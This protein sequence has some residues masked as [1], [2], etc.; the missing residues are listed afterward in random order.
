M[1]PPLPPPL[2]PPPAQFCFVLKMRGSYFRGT[3]S[4][5]WNIFIFTFFYSH[6]K[7][8]S[9]IRTV[10]FYLDHQSPPIRQERGLIVPYPV[11]FLLSC[12][13][14]AIL[15]HLPPC[16]EFLL[17][18]QLEAEPLSCP[19]S[20]LPWDAPSW[21]SMCPPV[22]FAHILTVLLQSKV[23]GPWPFPSS[24]EER[25]EHGFNSCDE[26]LDCGTFLTLEVSLSLLCALCQHQLYHS[27][28]GCWCKPEPRELEAKGG[29][30]AKF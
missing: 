24:K 2:P 30:E 17:V 16:L 11:L 1:P 15:I 21:L 7:S 27:S 20:D 13:S 26:S 29:W 5:Q 25:P 19:L 28:A 18:Q 3:R 22:L 8:G 12:C 6:H 9:Y 4:F 14:K 23:V 10:F